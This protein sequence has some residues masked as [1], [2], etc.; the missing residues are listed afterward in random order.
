VEVLFVTN[1]LEQW[2]KVDQ[3][4]GQTE[5]HKQ[6]QPGDNNLQDYA[7]IQTLSKGGAVYVVEPRDAPVHAPLAAL[8]RY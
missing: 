5:L 3:T 2:G 4:T 6:E 1:R 7:A 8:F